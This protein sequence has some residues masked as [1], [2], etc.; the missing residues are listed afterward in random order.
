MEMPIAVFMAVVKHL[1][2]SKL[3]Q[4]PEWR[5]AYFKQKAEENIL[6]NKAL[7]QTKMDVSGLK[8]FVGKL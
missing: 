3:M 2:M 6:K 8:S 4:K 5:E 7:A 1:Q